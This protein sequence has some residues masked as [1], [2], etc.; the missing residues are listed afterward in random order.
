[1]RTFRPLQS[2]AEGLIHEECHMYRLTLGDVLDQNSRTYPDKVATVCGEH[3]YTYRQLRE[4]VDR[5]AGCLKN[6]GVGEGDRLLW[7]G[8][9][10]HRLLELILASARLGAMTCPVNWRQ[11]VDE[12]VFVIEDLDPKVVVWQEDITGD[13]SKEAR[14]K[15][16][17]EALWVQ[18]DGDGEDGY[19]RLLAANEPNSSFGDVDPALPVVVM[20]TAAF[21][22]RPNGSMITQLGLLTQ[23]ANLF[24]LAEIT[25]EYVYLN[26]GPLFHIGSLMFTVATFHIGGTN[27]FIARAEPQYVMEAISRERCVSGFVL[28]PTI[29]KIVELN[30]DGAHDLTSFRSPFPVPGW[31]DM[32]SPDTSAFFRGGYGQTEATGFNCFAG[33]GGKAGVST[34]GRPSP[35]TRVYILDEDGR[36]VPQG[37]V[38]EITFDG[39][40]VHAGYWNRPQINAERTRSGGWRTNDLGLRDEGGIINFIGPKTQMIKSGVENIYP[41]EVE[42]CI[43]EIDAVKEAAIIGVPDAQYVQSVKA[44]IVVEPGH[45]VTAEDVI[46][47]C[48]A[49]IASYKKPKFVE[50]LDALPRLVTGGK[51]YA[52]LDQKFGGGGY[53]GGGTRS[54]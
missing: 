3:R 27:V 7:L 47:H 26:C 43:E 44:I 16:G 51:D 23:D 10:C 5:L 45:T 17:G 13:V 42:R 36:E 50:F 54:Q 9:N 40:M 30:A 22:G 18:H 2:R 52:L 21:G 20:Y 46:A 29:E 8:Q 53:P 15:V 1:M 11:S 14:T 48:K 39:P 34:A 38:G 6:A 24:Y 33:Y 32:V 35:W 49:R 19:E 28:P 31:V 4:R 25:S 41:A 37:E 12:F